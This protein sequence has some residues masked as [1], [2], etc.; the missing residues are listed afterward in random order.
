MTGPKA[1]MLGTL[2]VLGGLIVAGVLLPVRELM[3]SFLGWVDGLGFWAPIVFVLLYAVAVITMMPTWGLSIGAGVVF[4]SVAGLTHAF[5]GVALGGSVA[6]LLGRT[7]M[8]ETVRGWIDRHPR[9][10]AIDREIEDRGWLAGVLLRLSPATPWNILNYG[11]GVTRIPFLGFLASLPAALPVLGL[12]VML[13]A[14][15][16]QVAAPGERAFT[17]WEWVLLAVGLV[18]T[19]VV[20]IWLVRVARRGD[21]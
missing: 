13:G 5:L 15:A 14:A 19:L 20:T 6:F 7:L 2:L 8:G 9:L 21:A 12:Y 17:V 3:A 1:R 16:G 18:C 10:R 4:G 11:L